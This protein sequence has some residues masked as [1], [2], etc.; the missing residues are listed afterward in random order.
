MS[1]RNNRNHLRGGT[2]TGTI[3]FIRSQIFFI[4]KHYVLTIPVSI[5]RTKNFI[6]PN[7]NTE[8]TT[9]ISG[10]STALRLRRP[11]RTGCR[12]VVPSRAPAVRHPRSTT[13]PGAAPWRSAGQRW[14]ATRPSPHASQVLACGAWVKNQSLKNYLGL[15]RTPLA[16]KTGISR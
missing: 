6:P 13:P 14:N 1:H 15:S 11:A 4:R 8:K 9:T 5:S 2:A 16:L 7:F 3:I 10:P 12:S